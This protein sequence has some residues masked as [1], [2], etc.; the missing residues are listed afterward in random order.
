MNVKIEITGADSPRRLVMKRLI[1]KALDESEY[2]GKQYD[3]I[4]ECVIVVDM[5]ETLRDHDQ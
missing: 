2:D 3:S 4:G 1:I 5:S